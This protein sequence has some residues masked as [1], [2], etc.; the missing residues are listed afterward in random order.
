MAEGPQSGLAGSEL[1]L[2]LIGDSDADFAYLR[3]LLSRVEPG[4]VRLAHAHSQEQTLAALGECSYDLLLCDYKSEEAVGA[5]LLHR[6]RIEGYTLPLIFLSDG[7]DETAVN[8]AIQ[9]GVYACLHL[10]SENESSISHAI[11]CALEKYYK[12]RQIHKAEDTL[13]RLHSAVEQSADM[14]V[15]TDGR[16]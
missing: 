5:G 14:V 8:T 3:R 11:R 13:R 15:I 12:E 10:A 9:F 2:L 4:T 6:L 1:R 16:A 7:V